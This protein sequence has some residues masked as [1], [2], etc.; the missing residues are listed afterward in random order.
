MKR[1]VTT[2]LILFFSISFLIGTA[3]IGTYAIFQVYEK[4]IETANHKV[5]GDSA[6][7]MAVINER[8]P[9]QWKIKDGQLY[10]GDQL[11]N[12]NFKIV[13]EIGDMTGS[14]VTIFMGNTRVA[15]N[16]KLEDNSRAV[17]T[18]VST[19]IEKAVIEK[20]ETFQGEAEVVGIINQSIYTPIKNGSGETIG[21]WFTGVPNTPY[22][23]SAAKVRNNIIAV[24]I[25]MMVIGIILSWQLISRGVRPLI[26]AAESVNQI[27]QGNLQIE[28]I[29]VRSKDEIGL[30]GSSVNTMAHNLQ[31]LIQQMDGAAE[32]VA[33]SSEELSA[34]AEQNSQASE[35]IAATMEKVLIGAEQQ[36]QSVESMTLLLKQTNK[37]LSLVS[38]HN[39]QLAEYSSD[40]TEKTK[41]GQVAI[42]HAE[43][44]IDHIHAYVDSLGDVVDGLGKRSKEIGKITEVITALADQTN[45]LALNAAIEA[46]RAGEHGRGFAVVSEEVRRL[47]EQSADSANQIA[48]LIASIQTETT[49]A[50][51]SM[52][53]VT[54]EVTQGKEAVSE[55]GQSFAVIQETTNSV[56]EKVEDVSHQLKEAIEKAAEIMSSFEGISTT[57]E[58]TANIA[59][60]IFT[61][62]EEQKASAEEIAASVNTLAEM[63]SDLQKQIQK[64]NL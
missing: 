34:I 32:K 50:V 5:R 17:G 15:T 52:E 27:A 2:K 1:S 10:K 48:Q 45:L 56:T 12:N 64:F 28:P 6:L 53:K 41:A 13:D 21:I 31:E 24:V 29:K 37:N 35:Q 60:T 59:E 23:A 25:I 8:Y 58:Q 20:D 40:S 47:A 30:L 63:G 11:M 18:T 22:E 33:V 42:R 4:T 61:S 16:V 51:E 3:V 19:A 57:A 36:A 54:A 44:Q 39:E 14:N 62:V 9:G 46:A 55:A 38:D 7:G 26:I 43:K 49:K